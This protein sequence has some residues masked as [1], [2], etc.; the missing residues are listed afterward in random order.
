MK[1]IVIIYHHNC[2][3]GFSG[4]WAAYKKFGNKAEYIGGKHRE[5]PPVVKNKEVYFIDFSYPPKIIKDFIKNNKR[6]TII[7]HHV[8]AQESAEM[9]QDYLFDIKHSGAVLA[10]KYFHPKKPVPQFL[11]HVEDVDLWSFKLANSRE[12]MTYIDT[13]EFTFP[14]WN[15]VVKDIEDKESKKEYIE[16]GKVIWKSQEKIIEKMIDSNAYLV[17]FEGHQPLIINAPAFFASEAGHMLY[18]RKPPLALVWSQKKN[19]IKVS[20]RSDGTVD[21]GQIALKYGGGGHKAAAAFSFDANQEKPWK[22]I[23]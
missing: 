1:P 3:D 9:T 11:K 4:A 7:D 14:K 21:V 5:I 12:I 6:V 17:D 18:E 2:P 13:F 23:G 8:T 19:R 15:K 22:V 16:K 20:L 10:W